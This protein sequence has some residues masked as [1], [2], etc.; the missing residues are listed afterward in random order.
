MMALTSAWMPGVVTPPAVP[1]A[2]VVEL[3]AAAAA[4]AAV[5]AGVVAA[6]TSVA[7]A[8]AA[9][10]VVAF[11]IVASNLAREANAAPADEAAGPAVAALRSSDAA[12][13]ISAKS[14]W[15]LDSLAV[16]RGARALWAAVAKAVVTLWIM[17]ILLSFSR[18]V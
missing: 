6:V 12:P 9:F 4:E 14:Y 11:A 13:K 16:C 18:R 2:A 7:V 8:A 3:L 5:V 17:Q 15:A 1:L 10:T